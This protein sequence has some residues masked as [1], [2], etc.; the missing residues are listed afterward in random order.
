MIMTK[1]TK[2][3]LQFKLINKMT[4]NYELEQKYIHNGIFKVA[5]DVLR[6]RDSEMN[7]TYEDSEKPLVLLDHLLK[8]QNGLTKSEICQEVN[9]FIIG[10]IAEFYRS[11]N[12]KNSSFSFFIL[13]L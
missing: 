1:M 12:Q 9:L 10:V 3:W 4:K 2:F 5:E 7:Q 13:G 8:K 6:A 11:I